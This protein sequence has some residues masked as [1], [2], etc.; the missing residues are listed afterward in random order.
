MIGLTE[1]QA[2]QR[3]ADFRTL[4]EISVLW[5]LKIA[6]QDPRA[7]RVQGGAVNPAALRVYVSHPY[8]DDRKFSR[9]QQIN[10]LGL[11]S[12]DKDGLWINGEEVQPNPR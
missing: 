9:L 4:K 1:D 2:S 12:L 3:L 6:F 11:S 10:Q 8:R 5:L 7:N